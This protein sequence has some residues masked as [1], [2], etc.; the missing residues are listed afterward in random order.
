[1]T[2]SGLQGKSWSPHCRCASSLPGPQNLVSRSPRHFCSFP[3]PTPIKEPSSL[4]PE[5]RSARGREG[6][7]RIPGQ[8]SGEFQPKGCRSEPSELWLSLPPGCPVLPVCH[9]NN[10]ASSREPVLVSLA[11]NAPLFL[12]L[13]IFFL[14]TVGPHPTGCCS[15]TSE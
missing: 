3:F 6:C 5:G 12:R 1:M 4:V 9:S 8:P 2:L 15:S 14:F 7:P 10:W 13:H 11:H